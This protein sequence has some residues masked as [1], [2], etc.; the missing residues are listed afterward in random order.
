MTD[1]HELDTRHSLG[2][3]RFALFLCGDASEAEAIIAETF[4]R[5]VVGKALRAPAAFKG[6]PLNIARN[7]YL[8]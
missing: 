4:V 5:A 8:E 3:Y 7:L 1:F 6:Y 2:I